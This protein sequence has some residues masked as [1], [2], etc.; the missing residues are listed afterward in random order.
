MNDFNSD[1]DDTITTT[2]DDAR[3][4]FMCSRSFSSFTSAWIS[5]S[6]SRALFWRARIP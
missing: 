4:S 2:H 6:S 3:G 1:E 5:L